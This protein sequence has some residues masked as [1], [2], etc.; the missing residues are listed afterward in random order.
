MGRGEGK[1]DWG[2][3]RWIGEGKDDNYIITLNLKIS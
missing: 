2:G 3:E 1:V